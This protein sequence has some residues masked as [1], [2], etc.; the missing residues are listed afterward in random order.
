MSRRTANLER[1]STAANIAVA[2]DLWTT[3]PRHSRFV[4][5]G[6]GDLLDDALITRICR[7]PRIRRRLGN[8][9]APLL[10]VSL[11]Y[12]SFAKWLATPQTLRKLSR[13]SGAVLASGALSRLIEKDDLNAISSA[14]GIDVLRFALGE[15]SGNIPMVTTVPDIVAF[16]ETE[17]EQIVGEFLNKAAADIASD[18]MCAAGLSYDPGRTMNA[19]SR[20][21]ALSTVLEKV[22]P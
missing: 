22:T 16:I 14:T 6:S 3:G 5:D 11:A 21:K 10:S 12:P 1:L 18:I 7:T 19:E 17:G 9:V 15:A 8:A 4:A 13:Y 2:A 20:A